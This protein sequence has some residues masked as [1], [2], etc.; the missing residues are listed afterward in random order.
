MFLREVGSH[1]GRRLVIGRSDATY[2]AH[3][4]GVYQYDNEGRMISQSYP[5][6]GTYDANNNPMIAGV[7]F[8]Y[9]YDSM[10]RLQKMTGRNVNQE[11]FTHG[12][13]AQRMEWF[14]RGLTD[15]TVQ[16]CNT[17]Q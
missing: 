4:D 9:T 14:K 7:S 17:F 16:A 2:P 13:S 1:F 5:G 8:A 3:L 12:S 11:T 10:G 15:G 6:S